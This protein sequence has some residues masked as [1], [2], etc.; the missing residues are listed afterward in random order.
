[1]QI[2]APLLEAVK[3]I[4]SVIDVDSL[5]YH[6]FNA[7]PNHSSDTCIGGP[8]DPECDLGDSLKHLEEPKGNL[9]PQSFITAYRPRKKRCVRR[10]YIGMLMQLDKIR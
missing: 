1:M 8:K 3:R 5:Q 7:F 10:R 4:S 2:I 9:I 6:S